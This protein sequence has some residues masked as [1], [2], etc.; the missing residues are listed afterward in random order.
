MTYQIKST[1]ENNI[2]FPDLD[3]NSEYGVGIV[4]P[5]I[6]TEDPRQCSTSVQL[7][8]PH[9]PIPSRKSIVTDGLQAQRVIHRRPADY[10]PVQD[11]YCPT[12][13]N[14]AGRD[15]IDVLSTGSRSRRNQHSSTAEFA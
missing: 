4:D 14:L 8:T 6:Y 2:P 5:G 9:T 11:Y 13:E 12:F 15:C 1:Q 3:I 10:T 7:E